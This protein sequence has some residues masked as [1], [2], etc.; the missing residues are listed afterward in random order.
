MC[1]KKLS[2]SATLIGYSLPVYHESPTAPYVDIYCYDPVTDSMRRKKYH[3]TPSLSKSR[4][5]QRAAEMIAALSMKLRAGWSPWAE[6]DGTNTL[7]PIDTACARYLSSVQ[8]NGRCETVHNYSSR[9]SILREFIAGMPV[10]IKFTYQ[11]DRAFVV[12][13]L[14]YVYLDRGNG[15]R[16]RNNYLGWISSFCSF[17]HDRGM[18]AENP[19]AG[20]KKIPTEEKKR[21]P[22]TPSMMRDLTEYLRQNDP[23][24]LLAVLMQYFT[25]IRPS[26]L[27]QLKINN[28]RVKE[29]SVFVP[30]AVSKN[31]RDGTVG[32]PSSLLE[33]ML[34]LKILEAPA[35]YYLFGKNFKPGHAKIDSDSFNKRWHKVRDALGW[36]DCYQFYSLKDTGIRDIAN[37]AGIVTARNQARHTDISTTNKYLQGKLGATPEEI[38]SFDGDIGDIIRQ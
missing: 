18:I 8:K 31:K 7:I 33:L 28:I 37:S 35:S 30:A 17:L 26:E 9:M 15:A 32:I 16:T 11:I 38:I 1:P 21:Q 24:F 34:E 27:S 12:S 10:P 36:D 13:F 2:S 3:I 23:Y 5:K 6:L 25:L 20:L 22:L 19:A 29:M 4:R 14:D